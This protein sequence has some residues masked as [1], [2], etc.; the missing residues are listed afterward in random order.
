[1]HLLRGAGQMIR[2]RRGTALW[3]TLGAVRD[4]VKRHPWTFVDDVEHHV[5]AGLGRLIIE[6]SVGEDSDAGVD[7]QRGLEDVS[8]KLIVRRAAARLAYR[9]FEHYRARGNATPETIEAW[10][11]VCRSDSEFLDIR[12]EWLAPLGGRTPAQ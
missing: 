8:T 1:M 7:V 2:W 12:N 10:E 6:S 5:L 11:E 3:A 4:V 9:L